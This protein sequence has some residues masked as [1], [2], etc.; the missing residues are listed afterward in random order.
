MLYCVLLTACCVP[1]SFGGRFALPEN[2]TPEHQRQSRAPGVVHAP[3]RQHDALDAHR[4]DVPEPPPTLRWP[5]LSVRQGAPHLRAHGVAVEGRLAG[6]VDLALDGG[7]RLLVT[8]PNGAG[9]STL[10]AILA[11]SLE[12]TSGYVQAAQGVRVARVTQEIAEQDPGLTAREVYTRHVGRLVARG[13]LRDADAVPLGSLGL[14]YSDALRTPVGRMSQGQQRRLDLAL[15]LAGRPGLI[16]LDEP[17]NHLS[18][19][20]VDELTN[21]IRDTSAAIVVAT[22]DRQLL[23]DLADW[24]R[25]ELEGSP[26]EAT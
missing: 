24:P 22:H 25:L 15:A 4:I 11:G 2:S 6:P 14:L 13:T 5:S 1:P 10:L 7:D 21:A 17:T 20:L 8:G 9:K 12:P 26:A 23:R 3:S 16:L 18:S 19:T